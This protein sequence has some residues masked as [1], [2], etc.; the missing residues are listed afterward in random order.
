VAPLR[1]RATTMYIDGTTKSVNSVPTTMPL[2]SMMPMLL[3]DFH[4]FDLYAQALSKIERGHAQDVG[5]VQEMFGRGLVDR[6]KL[7]EYFAASESRLYRYPAIDAK[8]FR[9]AV[10][11]AVISEESARVGR[12]LSAGRL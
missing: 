7:L 12:P 10:D 8:R 11:Q 5:D 3:L 6:V 1:V 2:T 4:H 9:A